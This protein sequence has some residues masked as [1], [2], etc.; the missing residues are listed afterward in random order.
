V[1]AEE[2]DRKAIAIQEKLA[3]ESPAVPAYVQ[4]LARSHNN[5]GLLLAALGK[6]VEAEEHDRKAIAIQE[7]LAA[8]YP[9]MPANRISLGGSYCNLGRSVRDAGKPADSLKW[10]DLAISLLA[11]VHQHD[12]HNATAHQFLQ[13]SHLNR[14]EALELLQR[15]AEAAEDW[16]TVVELSEPQSLAWANFRLGRALFDAGEFSASEAALDRG[17]EIRRRAMQSAGPN[18]REPAWLTAIYLMDR[19]LIYY[20][21]NRPEQAVDWFKQAQAAFLEFEKRWPGAEATHQLRWAHQNRAEALTRLNRY[22]ESLDDWDRAIE[23]CPAAEQPALRAARAYAKV[24][25]GQIE[26]AL[27]EVEELSQRGE[28][29]ARQWYGFACVHAIAS[30]KLADRKDEHAS[31]AVELLRQAVKAGFDDAALMSKDADL[32]PLRDRKDFQKLLAD[33]PAKPAAPP[34]HEKK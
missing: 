25:A 12:P 1:E 4:E 14:A 19:A 33:L 16:R 27:A 11:P 23:R 28:W 30:G 22:G 20:D 32:D 6:R 26:V 21:G 10:F 17:L 34:P 29:S 8:E 31:R 18:A 13:N 24:R 2:H 15:H 9:N 7:E 3:A 5:L